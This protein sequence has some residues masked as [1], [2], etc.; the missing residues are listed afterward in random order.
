[1]KSVTRA[2]D[3]SNTEVRETPNGFKF[4]GY[5]AIFNSLS[6]DL[7]GYQEM[8]S[9]G[10]FS[11]SL[12]ENPDIRLLINHDPNKILA[13]TPRTMRVNEDSRG[14][15]V[16]ADLPNTTYGNDLAESLSRGD[17]SQM[18]FRFRPV[19]STWEKRDSTPIEVL[20][21]VDLIE[22]SAV[23]FPAY[24]ASTASLQERMLDTAFRTLDEFRE[25]KQI[26]AS[27]RDVIANVMQMLQD[28][29][30]STDT[31]R[32]EVITSPRK[33]RFDLDEHEL[34]FS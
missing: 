17:I 22:V 25:G 30:D 1:M 21:D 31:T 33:L 24:P 12:Q 15:A 7:G 19:D 20:K 8:I 5:A 16:E 28:L 13:R 4:R 14:L 23:T 6:E 34:L 27:N 18:S 9:P 11:R 3:L 10:A 32:S 2:F 26:S 29:L